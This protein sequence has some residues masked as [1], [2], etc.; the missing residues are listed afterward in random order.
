MPPETC[1]P[2]G[3]VRGGEGPAAQGSPGTMDRALVRPGA[4][5]GS[6][7]AFAVSRGRVRSGTFSSEG[8]STTERITTDRSRK[9]VEPRNRRSRAFRHPP[10]WG[11][12]KINVGQQPRMSRR[13]SRASLGGNA[14]HGTRPSAPRF[15]LCLPYSWRGTTSAQGAT[16]E[17][18][19]NSTVT[20]PAAFS[21]P[22]GSRASASNE[23]QTASIPAASNAKTAVM[24][25]KGDVW[26]LP[27]KWA[28]RAYNIQRWNF[29]E[30]GGHFAPAEKPDAIIGDLREFSGSSD[31]RH[32]KHNPG[33]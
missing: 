7:K 20:R 6:S 23:T 10:N 29:E 1:R 28:E 13:S 4:G 31:S 14:S 26:N 32:E 30:K 9:D 3:S 33:R 16:A 18:S 15:F 24:Q 11:G 22:R 17:E 12:V 27:R 25:F 8:R 2:A 21:S 19:A 5:A